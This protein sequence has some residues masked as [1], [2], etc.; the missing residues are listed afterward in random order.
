[1]HVY[2]L[3]HIVSLYY[4]I[5]EWIFMKL[6]GDEVLMVPY[7][8]CCFSAR[9]VEGRIQ[10]RAKIGHEGSPSSMNFFRLE[11]YSNKPNA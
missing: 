2:V 5:A 7:K 3:E 10:G 1:M 9:S 6:G 11:G 4:R 8:C